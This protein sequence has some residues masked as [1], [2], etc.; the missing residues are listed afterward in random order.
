[1]ESLIISI[2]DRE[3]SGNLIIDYDFLIDVFNIKEIEFIHQHIINLLWHAL[4]NPSKRIS[5]LEMIS[6]KEKHTILNEF[7]NTYADYPR[8][9]T[10]HQ[11]IEEQ[12]EK[13]PGNT[14]LIFNDKTMTYAE[15]NEKSNRLAHTLREKGVGP[16]KIVGIMTYRSFE[17]IIGIMGILKAGG[18]YMPIDPEYPAE[19]KVYM[20]E[21]SC[22]QILLTQHNM[23][24]PEFAGEV[25][26]L[27]DDSNYTGDGLN[28][29]ASNS[30]GDL[31]Y[32]IYTS[33]S[34]GNPKGVMI[35]HSG[36]VNSCCW[37]VKK[38]SLNKDSVILQKTAPTFDPSVWEIF[39][40]LM[41][42]GKVCLI[43]SGDEKD[44]EAIISA[45]ERNKVTV[46]HFVPSM[47]NIFLR[48]VEVTSSG[49]RLAS[50]KQV[51]SC[52][53]AI[54]LSQVEEFNRVLY[55]TNGTLLYNM[56]GPTEATVEVA[57]YDCSPV[58]TLNSVPIGMRIDNFK[59]YILD[60][61]MNILPVGIPGEIFISGTG[62]GRGY[63]NSPDLTSERF[64]VNPF[65]HGEKMYR[66]GDRARWYPK[67]DI[68]FLGRMDYQVKIRGFRI[69]LGE[70]EAR[71][72][73]HTAIREAVVKAFIDDDGLSYL[74]AYVVTNGQMSADEIQ[75]YLS[76]S[77]PNY[78]IPGHIEILDKM[79]L[80]NNG[81][82]D[83]NALLAPRSIYNTLNEIVPPANE[84]EACLV[85]IW[86]K[87]LGQERI[88]VLDEY[89]AIGGDSLTAIKIIT[90]I[91]KNFGVEVS[92]KYVF[93]LQT[94]R[95]LAE[96]IS[97]LSSRESSYS[98]IPKVPE[99]EYYPVSAAQKRQYIMN[100]IDRGVSY[101]LLGG[102]EI[103][104]EIDAARL[105]D[106]FRTIIRRHES[107]R[108]SFELR[109][110]VPVQ[111]VHSSVDFRVEYIEIEGA[112]PDR[113]AES[114]MKP[115][116]LSVPPLLRAGLVKTGDNK[117][118]LLFDMHHIISDGESVNIIIKEFVELY[119]GSDLPELEIQYKDYSDWHNELLRSERIKKQEAYWLDRFS[120]E[121]PVL[122]MPVDFARPSF[123]SFKGNKL[124]FTIDEKLTKGIK[125][126][127]AGT[128]TTLFMVLLASYNVLLSKY[129]GQEDIVVGT[130]V[131]GRRHADLRDLIGMFV[132][133]LAIRSCPEGG[134]AFKAYLSEV[135]EDLLNAYDNQE[136]PFEEL[137]EKVAVRRDMSRNPL[138]DT[139]FI[140]QNMDLNEITM[141]S[142]FATSYKLHNGTSKF[143]LI[144]EAVDRIDTFSCSI[145]YCTD[146][147]AEETMRHL[148]EHYINALNDIVENPDKRLSDLELLTEEE[149]HRLLHEFNN[150]YADYPQ[151]KT[152]YQIFE[153]Q[154]EKT[155]DNKALIFGGKS[156]TYAELNEKSNRL[157]HMLREK[158]VGPDKIV[159]IMTYR[160]F[161]ML[162]GILGILKAGGAYMPIDPDYPM[163]RK[164]YML[165]N[166]S[167]GIL[168]TQGGLPEIVSFEGLIIDLDNQSVYSHDASNLPKINTPRDLAYVI[169]TSGSTGNPKGVMVEHSSVV[170]RLNWMQKK[171][172]L[173]EDSVIMQKTTYT[174]DVS[175][176]ELFWWSFAGASV[177][178]VPPGGEKDPE[179]M[180]KLIERH[181]ITTMHFVPSML[182]AF[183]YYV[184]NRNCASRL[185]SL[186][187]VFASGEALSIQQVHAFNRLLYA[188]NGTLLSNLYGPT[189]A[190]VDVSYFDCS[191]M[192]RLSSVPIGKPIDNISL[193]IF[194]K[195]QNLLPV[196]F[197]GELYIG[198][199]GVARGYLNNPELTSE[200]FVINPYKSD[201]ILYRT[202][203]RARWYPKG[204]IEFLG[205]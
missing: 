156:M 22:A 130:P 184:E 75:A 181:E 13:T 55:S 58:I 47:M 17:M 123:Q 48:Y 151:D 160:S 188:G 10:I 196:G 35:Q 60:R 95:K 5:K 165:E 125:E 105:E 50:L 147:F 14:A 98:G 1:M 4:D 152:I 66:T 37:G 87:A 71:L 189:E 25:I 54:S 168:L 83:R 96:M 140:L 41:L 32:V 144:L 61:N 79:P 122:S 8:D 18:A 132:N 133:T 72:L 91:H 103:D 134:K 77:L 109:D 57:C 205:R 186:K 178:L 33:G 11:M 53:E 99:C 204:D 89:T 38:F 114:F 12:V 202:G 142:F 81:K 49:K 190:T 80:N 129:T 159:G 74:A 158:G 7:N 34:T 111:I 85:G 157:A 180:I 124:Y 65:V 106:V 113:L 121:I 30:S 28:L 187:N 116:D 127:A 82:T 150:T 138:F 137:V 185:A 43:E 67:G 6:E 120:G 2:N 197:P 63:L 199:V 29:P 153:E 162:I 15:L 155:P 23:L 19:R 135:K 21:N 146:L 44:P 173:D 39:W 64:L 9:K 117:H 62:V 36:V 171:Y 192:P 101:N 169:Y 175:V 195:N 73:S 31:A 20:L 161:E 201:E 166:S 182:S 164:N 52:G 126:L 200:K 76:D 115:F 179:A 139:M 92:P 56:Y 149:S 203:D 119:G 102:M 40:W 26:D 198:G 183:L 97:S 90:E 191:P 100:Q 167:S 94:I 45:I 110:G 59:I 170:N 112:D 177:C 145:E 194:D 84:A 68:E 93:Q 154:V 163:G 86:S 193:Y 3:D 176:W 131:E 24:F 136:Y 69:E 174:F 143:D 46:M 70:I 88:G 51:L 78:M 128:G 104:G 42:G 27:E 148:A 107:L 141:D 118:I 172:P 108:T 16:D